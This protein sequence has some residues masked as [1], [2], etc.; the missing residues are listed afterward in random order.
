MLALLAGWPY[1]LI[2]SFTVMACSA[3]FGWIA[4]STSFHGVMSVAEG[5]YERT[6]NDRFGV[7]RLSGLERKTKW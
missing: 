3:G 5:G 2:N 4:L 1:A 7:F 6:R